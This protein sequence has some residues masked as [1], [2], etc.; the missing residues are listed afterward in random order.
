MYFRGN[1]GLIQHKKNPS[2]SKGFFKLFLGFYKPFVLAGVA[3]GGVG[4][5][6]LV[7]LFVVMFILSI[8]QK[9]Q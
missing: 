9:R 5:Y 4:N 2:I 3:P 7:P 1:D 8:Q 6:F